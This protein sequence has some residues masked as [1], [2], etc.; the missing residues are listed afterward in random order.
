M[1]PGKRRSRQDRCRVTRNVID[2]KSG[3]VH[4][5]ELEGDR[6]ARRGP[7]A[8]LNHFKIDTKRLNAGAGP[9][10]D[11]NTVLFELI[12]KSRLIAR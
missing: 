2:A 4:L 1:R 6:P 3:A 11:K 5:H 7:I 12:I 9:I 8:R 10:A